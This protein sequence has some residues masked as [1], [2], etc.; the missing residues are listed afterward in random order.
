MY[1]SFNKWKD[2]SNQPGTAVWREL[3]P[4]QPRG[5]NVNV[6]VGRHVSGGYSPDKQ[7]KVVSDYGF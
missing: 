4:D 7:H 1:S 6:D 5:S 3:S 2:G